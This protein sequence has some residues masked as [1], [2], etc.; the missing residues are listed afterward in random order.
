MEI[1]YLG[2][3]VSSECLISV[4][5]FSADPSVTQISLAVRGFHTED[6]AALLELGRWEPALRLRAFLT[7]VPLSTVLFVP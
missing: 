1:V 7:P 3:L 2:V 5:F 4:T 6:R